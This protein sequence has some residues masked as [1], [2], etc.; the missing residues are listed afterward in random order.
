MNSGEE[1]GLLLVNEYPFCSAQC[2]RP[3]QDFFPGSLLSLSQHRKAWAPFKQKRIGNKT[4]N[5]VGLLPQRSVATGTTHLKA[6]HP[7]TGLLLWPLLS[8]GNKG[9]ERDGRCF[10]KRVNHLLAPFFSKAAPPHPLTF[11]KCCGNPSY[12]MWSLSYRIHILLVS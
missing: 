3:G 7:V 8:L 11:V 4:G 6:Y 9:R 2:W 1:L 5:I 12:L 10:W